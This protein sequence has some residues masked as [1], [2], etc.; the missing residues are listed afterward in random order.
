[1]NL[2]FRS[3]P[4]V[5]AVTAVLIVFSPGPAEGQLYTGV[6]ELDGIPSV[7]QA[8]SPVTFSGYL[9]TTSGFAVPDAVIYIKD[10]VTFGRDRI[11]AT[12]LTDDAGRFHWTWVAQQRSSGNWDFYAVFE[13][14][15]N[16]RSAR[17]STE[18]VA[19][20]SGHT[21]VPSDSSSSR[22]AS[23]VLD[24][25]PS[26]VYAGES[27][28]FTGRLTSNGYPLAD[29][30]VKI[31]EDDPLLPDQRLGYQRTDR[32][33]EFAITWRVGAG[34]VE[35]D[36]D[37]YAAFDGDGTYQG[38][39]SYNQEMAVMKYGGS[40]DLDPIPRSAKVGE[41][42]T[43]SGT[44]SL[45]GHSTEGAVVY[46]MDEDTLT[47]DDLLVAAYVDGSGRFSANWLVT[48][49]DP[50]GVADIYAVFEGNDILSR[51]TTCDPGPTRAFGGMC[52]DTKK[53][54]I[55]GY[56]SREPPNVDITGPYMELYYSLPF[57][58]SPRVAIVPSPYSYDDVRSHIVPVK[59]GILMWTGMMKQEHGGSWD[60]TFDVIIPGDSFPSRP[61]VIVNLVTHDVHRSCY[62]D[63]YGVAKIFSNPK[64]P[65][66]T[67]V[68]STSEGKKRPDYEVSATAAHEFI[69]AV[70]LGHTFNKPGDL[71]CSVEDGINTCPQ[72]P[73]PNSKTPSD[74]N[75]EAVAHIYG[76][77]GFTM[78]NN[79]VQ[80]REVF[81][82]SSP[83]AGDDGVDQV[84]GVARGMSHGC[85]LEGYTYDVW[86][87]GET[88]EPG[89]SIWYDIC[90]TTPIYYSFTTDDPEDGFLLY[91][92][93][94][95]TDIDDFISYGAGSYY[96]CEEY[97]VSWHS[98]S[99][100]CKVELGSKLV[101]HN[102]GMNAIRIVDGYIRN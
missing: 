24:K 78:P 15:G 45:D 43:F 21:P 85:P 39:R 51:L 56:A 23:I 37:I 54:S 38:A 30:L 2:Y 102:D 49:V 58:H 33:G 74:L 94:P 41:T 6:L 95:E 53:I 80:Y 27:V 96:T 72:S 97:D 73:Y 22:R 31:N 66:Y 71:L 79:L 61:D 11:M 17:S 20:S 52:T 40:I 32:N 8:G 14:S 81:T 44:L 5:L 12:L 83:P 63:Y 34:L 91:L 93:P 9:T 42:V 87:D 25:I 77:D 100:T 48:D 86:V 82:G 26:A 4:L 46:I 18:A 88:I 13:G 59:E 76:T 55:S 67:W 47:R 64:V 28:T 10:D 70:G 60:V 89:W 69:H 99:N 1:M 75:L 101:I 90:S 68:C 62:S 19:V 84:P 16:V 98:K 3:A 36:F 65:V 57:Q 29:R 7:V 92:L 35:D 50:D